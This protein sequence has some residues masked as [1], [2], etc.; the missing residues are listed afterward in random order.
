MYGSWT[1]CLEK[2]EGAKF[3]CII[4]TN[5]LHLQANLNQ[6]V[7]SCSQLVGANGSLIVSG[8]NFNR[9][10]WLIKRV[11]GIGDFGK[12]RS[13]KLSGISLC[14]PGT[15]THAIEEAGLRIGKCAV[16]QPHD[17]T[18]LGWRPSITSWQSDRERLDPARL[19]DRSILSIARGHCSY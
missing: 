16:A 18:V 3:D 11:G 1:D 7:R 12:L 8:P 14:G 13:F 5:L 15:L 10:P 6:L 2:L 9:L 4:V 17:R 19:P